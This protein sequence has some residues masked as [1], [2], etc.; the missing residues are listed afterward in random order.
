MHQIKQQSKNNFNERINNIEDD[1]NQKLKKG[2]IKMNTGYSPFNTNN[3]IQLNEEEHQE[4]PN[5]KILKSQNDNNEYKYKLRSY[6]RNNK[7]I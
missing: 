3:N 4:K 5:S 2:N 6:D 7:Q 1:E